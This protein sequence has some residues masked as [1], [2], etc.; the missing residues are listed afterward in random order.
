MC[1]QVS[2]FIPLL[3]MLIFYTN[4]PLQGLPAVTRGKG[5]RFL[6]RILSQLHPNGESSSPV[7]QGLGKR[8]PIGGAV[9]PIRL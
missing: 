4:R 7:H 9:V 6:S 5:L 8:P 3:D 1:L 2:D